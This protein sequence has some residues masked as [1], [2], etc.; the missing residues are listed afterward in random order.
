M[1]FLDTFINSK[2]A[3]V[4]LVSGELGLLFSVCL[5]ILQEKRK[6]KW[7]D[8]AKFLVWSIFVPMLSMTIDF[9]PLI[10]FF[11]GVIPEQIYNT[12]NKKVLKRLDDVVANVVL[13]QLPITEPSVEVK[14]L[15]ENEQREKQDG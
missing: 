7:L 10:A 1:D 8:L 14:K 9:S 11:I 5:T 3:W 15:P 12:L 4:Y 13:K 2:Q 6:P